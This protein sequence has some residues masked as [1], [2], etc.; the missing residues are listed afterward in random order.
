[1]NNY[2]TNNALPPRN[3]QQMHSN[4]PHIKATVIPYSNPSAKDLQ[5]QYQ[6]QAPPKLNP[7]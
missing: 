1:M 5:P 6:L 3:D 7:S 2:L 4:I